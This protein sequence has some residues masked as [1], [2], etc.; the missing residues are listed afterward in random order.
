[1]EFYRALHDH[2]R[3]GILPSQEY[4]KFGK[5]G[6]VVDLYIPG[7]KFGLEILL[8]GR[9]LTERYKRFLPGGIIILGS[10]RRSR[11]G[12]F[13]IFGPAVSPRPTPVCFAFNF[14]FKISNFCFLDMPNLVHLYFLVQFRIVRV[15]NNLGTVIDEVQLR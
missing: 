15:I 10:A 5:G 2:L 14:G 11:N 12:W 8:E 3:G 13:S 1:M 4:G 7:Y 6:G 9:G